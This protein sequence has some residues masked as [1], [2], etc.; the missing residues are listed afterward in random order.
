MKSEKS[1]N[2]VKTVRLEFSQLRIHAVFTRKTSDYL[3]YMTGNSRQVILPREMVELVLINAAANRIAR[4]DWHVPNNLAKFAS[5]FIKVR[6]MADDFNNAFR[7]Y[8]FTIPSPQLDSPVPRPRPYLFHGSSVR[9]QFSQSVWID[10]IT[11][12]PRIR[13]VWRDFLYK[14][15]LFLRIHIA[16]I[17]T[18]EVIKIDSSPAWNVRTFV[19][20]IVLVSGF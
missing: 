15:C 2:S 5:W 12:F 9:N 18:R 16:K 8:R 14:N 7:F 11:I 4:S 17:S 6:K 1:G 13:L 3:A 10:R 20:W 19:I